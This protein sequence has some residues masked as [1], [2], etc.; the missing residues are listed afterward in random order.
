MAEAA[1]LFMIK[2]EKTILRACEPGDIEQ[3]YQWEN[4][5]SVWHVTNTYIPFSK[6]T[7]Q[8]YLDSIQDIYTDR[9]LR[10]LIESD[11]KAVGMVDLF[12]FEPY[13]LRAGLGILIAAP[14]DRNNGLATDALE[15]LKR[16]CKET[17]GMRILFCNVLE[18]N[19]PSLRLFEKC[20]FQ[21]CGIKPAWHRSGDTMVDEHF[22]QVIL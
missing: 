16:Y 17:L 19:L 4:D 18:S 3:L 7:L 9:Q 15:T 1:F 20:G 2:G 21:H 6:H 22:L 13:H 12:D 10:L 14:G 5:M 8:K 11:G